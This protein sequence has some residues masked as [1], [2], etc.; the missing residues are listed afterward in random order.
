MENTPALLASATSQLQKLFETDEL[1]PASQEE[2]HRKL[3]SAV[4]YLLRTDLNRLMHIL[5]RIDV[6]EQEVRKAMAAASE[7]EIA[8]RLAHLIIQRELQKAHIRLRYSQR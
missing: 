4:R 3:T 7:Q 8:E 2:V 5:Y 6:N 1:P